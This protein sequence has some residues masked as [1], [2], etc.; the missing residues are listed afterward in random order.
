MYPEVDAFETLLRWKTS[1]AGGCRVLLHPSWGSAVYPASLF[2]KAP[3][4][5]LVPAM[6][7]A[8]ASMPIITEPSA[9]AAAVGARDVC[10]G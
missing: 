2:T 1:S 3:L 6:E 9:D 5:A 4:P 10:L 8:A 7:E